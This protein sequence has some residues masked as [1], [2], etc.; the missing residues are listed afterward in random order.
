MY[1]SGHVKQVAINGAS[2]IIASLPL[3]LVE[4]AQTSGTLNDLQVE[5]RL[6]ERWVPGKI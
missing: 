4:L 2:S 5:E 3:P 1:T 6:V